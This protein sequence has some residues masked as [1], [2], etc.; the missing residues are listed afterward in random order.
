MKILIFKS[1]FNTLRLCLGRFEKTEIAG[2]KA[3]K[4][5]NTTTLWVSWDCKFLGNF[6]ILFFLV[7]LSISLVSG[8]ELGLSPGDIKF[9]GN[10]G[11]RICQNIT[12]HTNYQGKLIGENKWVKDINLVR[13]I[14]NYKYNSQELGI[15][16]DYQSEIDIK[17]EFLKSEICLTA[18]KSGN[19]NGAIIYKTENDYAGVGAWIE[20]NIN[21]NEENIS[22]SFLL[23]GFFSGIYENK[24][25]KNNLS[26]ISFVIFVMLLIMLSVLLVIYK[27]VRKV[28][29]ISSL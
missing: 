17:K 29:E 25:I 16:V 4:F 10:V 2:R 3:K 9:N 5:A 13:K 8:I 21:K 27:K 14:E 28:N 18:N 1:G 20:V 15:V 24:G 12:I 22:K 7:F 11:E 6:F 23:T 26:L 19:Y